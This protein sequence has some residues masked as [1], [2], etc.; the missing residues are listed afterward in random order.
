M[1][2]RLRVLAIDVAAP[3]AAIAGLVMIGVMLGWPL[4][5][6]SACSV[7]CLLIVQAVIVNIVGYRRE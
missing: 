2:N 5:W 7:L 1:R 3:L 4:W 6:V